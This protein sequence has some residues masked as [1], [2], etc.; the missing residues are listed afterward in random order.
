MELDRASINIQLLLDIDT[1]SIQL[2]LR[3]G[4]KNN[5]RVPS[6]ISAIADKQ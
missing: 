6:P 5:P 3:L 4:A 1:G 2:L